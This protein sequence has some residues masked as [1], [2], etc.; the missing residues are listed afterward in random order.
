[1]PPLE[2]WLGRWSLTNMAD[3]ITMALICGQIMIWCE[4]A[5]KE[6]L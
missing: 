5:W 1:M 4:E 2:L 3:D 6:G